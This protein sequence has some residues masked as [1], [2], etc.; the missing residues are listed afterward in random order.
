VHAEMREVCSKHAERREV[1]RGSKR[2]RWG[3]GRTSG[4]EGTG[5]RCETK[6]ASERR[7]VKMVRHAGTLRQCQKTTVQ[8]SN[9]V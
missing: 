4:E 3:G 5:T 7:R 8:H 2:R 1:G 9:L 6:V